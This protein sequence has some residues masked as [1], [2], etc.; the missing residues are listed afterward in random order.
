M[1]IQT[2]FNETKIQL[3]TKTNLK[4]ES[5]G[6]FSYLSNRRSEFCARNRSTE[7]VAECKGVNCLSG[8]NWLGGNL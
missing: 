7:S 5:I 8:Q 2:N 3:K 1:R 4:N 6:D